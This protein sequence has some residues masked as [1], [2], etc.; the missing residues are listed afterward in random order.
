MIKLNVETS[1]TGPELVLI[2]GWAMNNLAWKELLRELE[3]SY[4]VTCVELPGHGSSQHY[5]AW[6][7]DELLQTMNENLP[8]TCSILGWSLGGMIAL[9]YADQYPSR[10]E[11]LIML[12]SSA[13]FVQAAGWENAQSVDTMTS[14]FHGV[15]SDSSAAIKRFLMLQTQGIDKSK[16]LNLMLKEILK[17]G[18]EASGKG[19]KSGLNVLQNADLREQLRTIQCP[20]LMIF[21]EK[22]PLVPAAVAADS[23]VINADINVLTIGQASHV[24]FLSHQIDVLQAVDHFMLRDGALK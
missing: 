3:K 1:G 18:G 20:T 13:K 2:H 21:G 7:L 11:K 10:V 23:L 15:T 19:L 22:D 8:A 16:K 9:A 4:R 6:T 14:F 5:E 17:V 24:A 12:A